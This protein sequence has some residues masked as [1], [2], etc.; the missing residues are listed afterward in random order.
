LFERLLEGTDGGRADVVEGGYLQIDTAGE[1][2]RRYTPTPRII[3]NDRNQINIFE[4]TRP[5]FYTK[6]WRRALFVDND[7]WFP[8]R[9]YFEDLATTPRLLAKARRI[10]FIDDASYFY[11]KREGSIT[12]SASERHMMD[13]F[14]VFDILLDFLCENDLLDRYDKQFVTQIG[15][16]LSYHAGNVLKFDLPEKNKAQYLRHML[17]MAR[18]YEG[19]HVELHN[20]SRDDLVGLFKQNHALEKAREL[21]ELGARKSALEAEVS[22]LSERV[23]SLDAEIADRRRVYQDMISDPVWKLVA[24]LSRLRSGRREN[25]KL[26]RAARQ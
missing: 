6:L 16:R 23:V 9:L 20:A 5:A 19:S 10:H 18:G 21:S 25:R 4:V 22:G 26:K 15:N 24:P 12:Y 14:K 8:P 17:M 11:L 7:I 2:V 3:E 1:V 13:H